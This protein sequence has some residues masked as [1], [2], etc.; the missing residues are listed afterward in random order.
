LRT[1]SP[2]RSAFTRCCRIS[3]L[4]AIVALAK[5]M[6]GMKPDPDALRQSAQ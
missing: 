1:A 3:P 6:K 2:P 5:P 4:N